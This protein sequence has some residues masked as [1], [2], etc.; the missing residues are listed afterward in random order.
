MAQV[1]ERDHSAAVG[2][3]SP[4]PTEPLDQLATSAVP[5]ALVALA[6]ATA[7]LG[8]AILSRAVDAP[9]A[10]GLAIA[11][12]GAVG[13]WAFGRR[14]PPLDP[15]NGRDTVTGLLD[16]RAFERALDHQSVQKK[17]EPN[18][19]AVLMLDLDGFKDVNDEYGPRVGD[20]VL[21]EVGRRMVETLRDDD[22]AAR[23]GADEFALFLA[24]VARPED[25][26]QVATRVQAALSAPFDGL[27]D[28]RGLSCTIG[29]AA[30]RL[31]DLD[32]DELVRNSGL[33]LRLAKSEARGGLYLFVDAMRQG[34]DRRRRLE[35]S[36]RRHAPVDTF[37]LV[38]QPKYDVQGGHIT[39][40]EA[41][42]RW[43]C[44][45]VGP[46]SP[47]EFIPILEQTGLIVEVGAFVL[48]TACC[49]LRA[50]QQRLARPTLS[51][52]VNLSM[53]QLSDPGLLETV[54]E[55]LSRYELSPEHL[56]LEVTETM[57]MEKPERAI[58]V[59]VGLRKLGVKISVDDFGTGYSSLAYL[60]KLPLSTLKV[61]RSFVMSL[62]NEND[63][64]IVKATI[65][66]AK[67][68]GLT[69]VAEGVEKAE[70]LELLRSYGCD[71]AQGYH[72]S[73]PIALADAEAL[74]VREVRAA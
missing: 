67:A 63:A 18:F 41:L 21:R 42:L 19:V 1:I 14:E 11:I 43:K 20:R 57:I 16:R 55:I 10:A 3:P 45:E 7:G 4:G 26:E 44:P 60:K 58:E 25:A 51:M 36:L 22:V 33:A 8:T 48:D 9:S 72:L 35:A 12:G 27:P 65:G 38:Y 15:S 71:L 37:S 53:R 68:L 34:I 40:F 28:G 6:G 13:W 62:P 61:D 64:V 74:L 32:C 29:I 31:P 17:R 73:R 59:L 39:G 56:E 69:V 2:A 70:Q 54:G 24:S 30:Q 52:A 46:V 47:A 49:T 5:R 23:L 50:W 66:L